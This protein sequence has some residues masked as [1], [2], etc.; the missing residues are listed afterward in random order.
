MF[1]M[2]KAQFE[3]LM[4][5]TTVDVRAIE[6]PGHGKR[7]SEAPLDA[8]KPLVQVILSEIS[9]LCVPQ[10]SSGTQPIPFCLFGYSFGSLLAYEVTRELYKAGSPPLHLFVASESCPQLV[11]PDVDPSLDDD[12]FVQQLAEFGQIQ[13]DVIWMNLTKRN[14]ST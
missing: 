4:A 5:G 6:I 2:W 10:H 3:T 11:R 12:I 9:E 1:E 8:L 7:R 14:R 13:R